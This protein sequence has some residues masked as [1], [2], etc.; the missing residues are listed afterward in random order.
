MSYVFWI[1]HETDSMEE[2]YPPPFFL[3]KSFFLRINN[4][5][6]I[7]LYTKTLLLSHTLHVGASAGATTAGITIAARGPSLL[8]CTVVPR[9]HAVAL[10]G[11]LHRLLQRVLGEP[12]LHLASARD[13]HTRSVLA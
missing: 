10:Q 13:S 1:T 6:F 8:Q 7:S 9:I 5:L 4:H 3:R 12:S 11:Q 2:S